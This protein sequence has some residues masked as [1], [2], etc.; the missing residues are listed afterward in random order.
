MKCQSQRKRCEDHV[1]QAE[2]QDSP[3]VSIRRARIGKK[4]ERGQHA[5]GSDR[6]AQCQVE[7]IR[8]SDLH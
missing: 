4:K 2:I 6:I 5:R 8:I 1:H 7:P 3:R